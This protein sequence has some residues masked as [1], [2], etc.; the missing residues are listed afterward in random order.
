MNLV[1]AESVSNF[2]THYREV[3]T[4]VQTEGPVLLLQNSQVA[5]VLVSAEEWNIQ[6]RRLRQFELL[7]EA[8]RILADIDSGKAITTSHEE[9]VRLLLEKRA[10]GAATHVGD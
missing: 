2:R 9:L 7:A 8:K 6:Q 5:A 10:Q 1:R 4:K 3:L